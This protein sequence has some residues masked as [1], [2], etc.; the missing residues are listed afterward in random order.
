MSSQEKS[1]ELDD[2]L[3]SFELDVISIFIHMILD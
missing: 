3:T 2:A 1:F